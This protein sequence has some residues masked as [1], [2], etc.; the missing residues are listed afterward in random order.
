MNGECFS[1]LICSERSG[2]NLVTG[3]LNGHPA[4][5]APPP[6]HLF[7]LFAS[8][9][10]NY[11]DLENDDN[12]AVLLD[13]VVRVFEAQ[14]GSWNT[15]L[16]VEDLAA[17]G[18]ERSALAPVAELYRNEA[19]H[20]GADMVFVKENHTARFAAALRRAMPG[21]RF[22]FMVR[23]PRDVAASYL[24]TDGIPG[25]VERAVEVWSADQ[26]ETLAL[27]RQPG[28]Q[29][30]VH[31]LRYEDL[32][33]DT[34][35]E[36]TRAAAFLGLQ[37][38]PAMLAFNR[39]GRTRRNAER[40]D[41]WKNLAQPVQTANSGKYRQTLTPAEI[42]YVELRCQALMR[43][44]GYACDI[45]TTLPDDAATARRSAALQPQLRPG[46]YRIETEAEMDIRK[47]RQA[48]ID[49]V[50]ARRLPGAPTA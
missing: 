19:A 49:T 3:I 34:P 30:A 36:L 40:I 13:D 44:F 39:D 25:G 38:D 5:S 29:G 43:A 2:S 42:E 11:G 37:Y 35:G 18:L 8:N 14:L 6:S 24:A 20:D 33:A 16:G 26:A 4:I 28:M 31:S 10:E 22:V 23:D 7:R 27:L 32:L 41:A 9:A 1:F 50:I 15:A 12:W 47:R 17:R 46:S 21:C 45:V 48:M